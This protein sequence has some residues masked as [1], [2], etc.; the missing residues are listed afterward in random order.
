MPRAASPLGGTSLCERAAD[1]IRQR[2]GSDVVGLHER[3]VK[4]VAQR[5]RVAR[6]KADVVFARADEGGLRD[7]ATCAR[8]PPCFAAQSST[9]IAVAIFVRLPTWR[10]LSGCNFSRI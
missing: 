1:V 7:A 10:F 8:S 5:D 6:L 3:R 9:T 2:I 4:Q